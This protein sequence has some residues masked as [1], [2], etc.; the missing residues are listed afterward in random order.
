MEPL[1]IVAA[2]FGFVCVW[3]TVRQHIACWPTGLVQVI[4]YIVVFYRAK[5]YSDTILQ[6]IYVFMQLYGWYA[7]LHG[8]RDGSKL[9]VTR[10]SLRQTA[11]WVLVCA[12]ATTCLGTFMWRQTD[13]SFPYVDA[14]VT[15]ASLIAQWLM[16]R[17][18]LES[19]L[20]WIVVDIVSIGL[21]AAK[22]L[23][24]TVILYAV[25]L[26]LAVWGWFAWKQSCR[27]TD[28]A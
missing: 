26:G 6:I 16:S 22:A 13:A 3:L 5:L 4:L 2:L 14:F 10:L 23:Y 27:G 15:I 25:F 8:G 21:F 18:I 28:K 1:E 7:W 11:L 12:F 19:W 24:P 9:T 20:V 17:K